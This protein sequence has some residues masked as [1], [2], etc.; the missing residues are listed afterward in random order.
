MLNEQISPSRISSDNNPTGHY[1][2]NLLHPAA[3]R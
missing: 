3:S 2:C 1:H